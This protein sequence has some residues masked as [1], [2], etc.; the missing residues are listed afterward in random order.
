MS[1]AIADF[2]IEQLRYGWQLVNGRREKHEQWLFEMRQKDIAPFLNGCTTLK[3]LDLA[4]GR[5]RPQYI[6][7]RAAG[8]NVYG[9]D[10]VN[11]PEH[12]R[13]E[14]SYRL[15]RWLYARNIRTNIRNSNSRLICGS[16]AQLPLASNSLDLVTSIAAFEHFYDVPSVVAEMHRVL[17]PRGLAWV[18]VH[19]FTSLSGGHNIRLA[20]TPLRNIPPG[21]EP[22]DHL[23]KR[24][25]TFHVPL[26]EWRQDQFLETFSQHFEI[27]KQYCAMREG[28]EFLTPAIESELSN[29]SRDELTCGAYVIL[30]RKS[31]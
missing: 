30:A 23:R 7:L 16:V 26:N 15:A 10:L 22:W 11:R 21:V 1:C 6:L 4:N 28:E 9:I 24:R 18:L 31:P 5:L 29:Y 20:E 19:L 3:I 14:M 2:F 25:L 27:I 12:S 13:V 17:Q 8:H